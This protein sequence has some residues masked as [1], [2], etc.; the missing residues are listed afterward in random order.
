MSEHI[1]TNCIRY[2][3][4]MPPSTLKNSTFRAKMSSP[5]RS[6]LVGEAGTIGGDR[7]LSLRRRLWRAAAA[8]LIQSTGREGQGEAH[9]HRQRQ[10]EEEREEQGGR[11]GEVGY[12]APCRHL[13]L[14]DTQGRKEARQGGLIM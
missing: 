3:R 13:P 1:V 12:H 4:F 7:A 2:R 6:T 10:D 9:S 14:Q 8:T 5:F 11:D